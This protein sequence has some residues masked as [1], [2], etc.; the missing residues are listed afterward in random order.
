MPLVELKRLMTH[1]H[2]VSDP[3]RE[4]EA[5]REQAAMAVEPD[6]AMHQI[7]T[8]HAWSGSASA[9]DRQAWLHLLA[10]TR[11]RKSGFV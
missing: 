10:H 5:A 3:L 4:I 8:W 6:R 9:S 2:M 7:Q 1:H 11:A